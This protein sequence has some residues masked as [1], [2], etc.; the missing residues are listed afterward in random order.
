MAAGW[1]RKAR[2]S[3]EHI[4]GRGQ[5][6][7]LATIA[8]LDSEHIR[9]GMTIGGTEV[10]RDS[11][12]SP[13]FPWRRFQWRLGRPVGVL[14]DCSGELYQSTTSP[15]SKLIQDGPYSQRSSRIIVGSPSIARTFSG[16][17]PN[18]SIGMTGFSG[19]SAVLWAM[20]GAWLTS[21]RNGSGSVHQNNAANTD[22]ANKMVTL[23]GPRLGSLI[24]VSVGSV[25]RK[26]GSGVLTRMSSAWAPGRRP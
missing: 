21:G 10:I 20:Y 1:R 4:P 2:C 14:S 18:A 22:K 11:L 6:R 3:V 19:T 17:I 13:R 25:D 8:G 23:E 26:V 16:D 24:G 15:F 7:R 12:K 9:T 5:T